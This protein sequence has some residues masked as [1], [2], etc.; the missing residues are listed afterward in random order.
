M[1]SLDAAGTDCAPHEFAIIVPC[2][3]NSPACPCG[4]GGSHAANSA[5]I[6]AIPTVRSNAFAH[7]MVGP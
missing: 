3:A 6:H 7:A 2:T 1:V 5:T 4:A